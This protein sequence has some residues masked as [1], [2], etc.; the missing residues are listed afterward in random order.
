MIVKA[1]IAGIFDDRPV[2]A[3]GEVVLKAGDSVETL[4]KKADKALGLKRPQYFRLA[5]KM[6]QLPTVLLNGDRLEMPEGLKH[7]LQEGDE[8]SVLTPMMGG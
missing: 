8:V 1:R 2:V 7:V 4:I 5:V 3:E 6:K